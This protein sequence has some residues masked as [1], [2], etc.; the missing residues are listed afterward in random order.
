MM[1]AAFAQ[2]K[3]FKPSRWNLFSPEQDVQMG[4]EAADEVR[5][6]MP[7]VN[8]KELTD[9]VNRIG[10]R[11]AASKHAGNFPYTFEVLNDPSINAFALPGGPMF[12]HTGL[13]ASVD[14]ESQLA[15]VLAHEMSHVALRHGSTNVSKANIIQLPAMLAGNV[16]GNKGGLWGTLGQLGIGLGAQSVLLK[17]SRDAE[18]EADLNG[19]Q[20]MNEAGYD[21]T[22]M[23]IFFDKLQAEGSRD[24]SALANF[25]SDHPTP[26]K[27]VDY[28]A[29]QNKL[30]PKIKYT[31]AE[32]QNLPKMKQIVA[33]LPPPPKQPAQAA[34]AVAGQGQGSG[35]PGQA[36]GSG[37]VKP[38]GKFKSA[39]GSDFTINY[40]DN[41]EVFGDSSA[42]SLTIA[43]RAGLIQNTKGGADIAYGMMTA[44]YFP[45]DKK[46][47]LQR[48]T[49]DLVKQIIGGNPGMQQT[50][51][52]KTV[53]VGGI[54]GL[55]TPLS[56]TSPVKG[57][58]ENDLL[59]TVTRPES[60]FYIMFVAPQ[61]DWS[62]VQPAFDN[63]VNSLRFTK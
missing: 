44:H 32:P 15:G 56:S 11:L 42:G 13:I 31:E 8:N 60:I 49:N 43:P 22:Q 54:N 30:L 4:K 45:P 39:Q 58:K 51:Q 57:Q 19:A 7:I 59:L 50:Q 41:W 5:K 47:N 40:P 52:A 16:L 14:N 27:R 23:A 35:Q 29:A 18:K 17:Y 61:S 62:S 9:Y 24:N 38:S 10:K 53:K 46:P 55:L 25:M 26:G 33:S 48:D 34:Q 3:E 12:V 36:V 2:V 1:G 21:P 28:V 63:A 37:E 6:T 20:I